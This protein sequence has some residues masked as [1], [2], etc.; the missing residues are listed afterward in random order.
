MKTP[1]QIIELIREDA[2]C[3]YN[4]LLEE[5]F[6]KLD[7]CPQDGT[8]YEWDDYFTA[9]PSVRRPTAEQLLTA[10]KAYDGNN[11]DVHYWHGR[12]SQIME[13]GTWPFVRAPKI[14][15]NDALYGERVDHKIIPI[16]DEP[17]TYTFPLVPPTSDDTIGRDKLDALMNSI[18]RKYYWFILVMCPE[19]STVNCRADDRVRA[20]D[21]KKCGTAF[22]SSDAPDLF[23]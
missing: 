13:G 10:L 18:T 22:R 17:C 3:V 5:M 14:S 7:P 21:N 15:L 20:C 19:C 6:P 8:D 4:I 23:F 2:P 9:H 12:Y 11:Y 1:E 16:H